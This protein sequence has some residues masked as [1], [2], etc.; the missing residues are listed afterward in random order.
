MTTAELQSL[1]KQYVWHPFTH[2]SLWLA[3]DPLVITHGD[4]VCLFDS[5]GKRYLDGIASLWCNVH[6]HR[7]K[8]ID[9]AIRA[10]LE[11]IAHSTLL[12]LANEPSAILAEKLIAIAPRGL[13]KVL[14]ASD[15]A[16]ATEM[17]FKLAV[18]YW[19]NTGKPRKTEFVGLREAYHGDTT[20]GM[21]VG[22]TSAFH[23]PYMP[24]LFKVHYAEMPSVECRVSNET[25]STLD[26]RHSTLAIERILEKHHDTIAAI[27]IEPVVMAAAGMIV[28]PDG[29]V[30]RLRELAD[31]Y[32]VLL[33]CD[34]VATGFGRTGRMFACDHDG[35]T[36]DLM[37]VGKGLTGGYLPLAATLATQKVFDAF[38]GAPHEG[39]TFFHGHTFTGNPLCCAAAIAS[40]G[41][42]E[43]HN[44]VERV[45][46][47]AKE[48][49]TM[50]DRLRSLPHVSA[51]RQKGFMVGIDL[52]AQRDPLRPFDPKR[53]VGAE[54]CR[55]IRDRGIILRPL[56]DTIVIFPPL[57]IE[58]E[59]L[60][61]IVDAVYDEVSELTGTDSVVQRGDEVIA[62]DY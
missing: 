56:G 15:G 10:Q 25:H 12:G 20:G 1:D 28:Q 44:L 18:Q 51:I 16:C 21:S 37:C 7:V 2:M 19:W 58:P 50:L 29:F 48:L 34:E 6:G 26:I 27:C 38:L 36:P 46:H 5:E 41:L 54:V 59:Q 52:V 33:I 40:I 13:A 11:R 31:R 39:K 49:S 30:R 24:L 55:K 4:G 45:E 43:K 57:V 62:G 22:M 47:N 9:D 60:R 53:R 32:D 42:F 35:V 3:D 17:A 14:Y 23:K 61:E 8:E